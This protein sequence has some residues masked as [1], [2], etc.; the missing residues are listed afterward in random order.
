M[1]RSF[2]LLILFNNKGHYPCIFTKGQNTFQ[3]GNEFK[4]NF[5]SE[6]PFIAKVKKSE[7]L[8]EIK[9]LNWLFNIEYK[10]YVKIRFELY[11]VTE[12]STCVLAYKIKIDNP[13]FIKIFNEK[14]K[15]E[16]ING[17]FKKIEKLLESEPINLFQY[18]SG[19]I[20]ANMKDIWDIVTDFNKL[21]LIAPNNN[22]FPSINT[23]NMKQE[24]KVTFTGFYNGKPFENEIILKFKDERPGW[25]KWIISLLISN[26]IPKI[27]PNQLITL[28]L[29]K[30]TEEKCQLI[31]FSKF[32]DSIDT[33]RFK[34]ISKRK[35]YVLY[36]LKDY[37]DNF[38]SQNNSY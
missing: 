3:V 18:E 9:I 35:K 8:P 25:N 13:E 22:C 19:I 1:I 20:N 15:S 12:D 5:F 17:L 14:I 32:H 11:K 29:T 2:D 10:H 31:F 4:G 36:S 27:Y 6:F 21:T 16:L 33:E 38:Y 24:E 34:E 37:F 28:E 26:A 30:I 7:S 23:K